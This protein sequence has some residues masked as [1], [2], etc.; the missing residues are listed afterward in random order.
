MG[1]RPEGRGDP[2]VART[3]TP[4]DSR[5]NGATARRPWR[6]LA[7]AYNWSPLYALQWG[8]GPKAVETPPTIADGM[9]EE[10]LQW[11]HGPKA[12]ETKN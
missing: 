8:H 2:A 4:T 11:G 9:V 1:P 12:V 10:M 3:A 7:P 5:F 6:H